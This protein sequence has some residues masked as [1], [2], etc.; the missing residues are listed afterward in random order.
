MSPVLSVIFFVSLALG[1]LSSCPS[2]VGYDSIDQFRS[3]RG[4]SATP[5]VKVELT[6]ALKEHGAACLDGTPG[7][8]YF[9][10][11]SESHK[12]H[13]FL[14]GGGACSGIEEPL[15]ECM[16]SCISRAGTGL[17]SSST[18]PKVLDFDDG[19]YLSTDS[20]INPL[21][22]DWN[23]VYLRYCDG[24]FIVSCTLSSYR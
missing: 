9:R 24:L 5:G 17:G 3:I 1:C 13:V 7:V 11:A 10:K 15:I 8:F 16:D 20:D 6:T 12:F 4:V 22:H 2:V 19:G 18:Y 23:T 14:E 21:T